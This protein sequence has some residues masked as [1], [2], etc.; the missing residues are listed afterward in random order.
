MNELEQ[1]RQEAGLT[2]REL[3]Q[4]SGISEKTIKKYEQGETL[5]GYARA[6]IVVELA[7]ALGCTAC[8]LL[9]ERTYD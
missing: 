8:R 5:P 6:D 7:T 3:S 2:V 4:K 9:K 1:A